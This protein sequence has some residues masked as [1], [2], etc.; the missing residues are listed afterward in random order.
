MFYDD[1]LDSCWCIVVKKWNDYPSKKVCLIIIH[2]KTTH[3]LD[4]S[5]CD[6]HQQQKYHNGNN[7]I[8]MYIHYI[9]VDIL[10][11][12]AKAILIVSECFTTH[13]QILQTWIAH[14]ATRYRNF[15]PLPHALPYIFFQFS[16][17]WGYLQRFTTR[18][19]QIYKKKCILI[20]S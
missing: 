5:C 2:R 17:V 13:Y 11:S 10:F 8:Y 6:K 3:L 19:R 1:C 20:F 14:N 4:T 9:Y 18:Y 7:K 15:N 12:L 16:M